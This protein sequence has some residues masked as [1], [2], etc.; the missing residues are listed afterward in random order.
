MHSSLVFSLFPKTAFYPFF[1]P[2]HI[3]RFQSSYILNN[4]D[5]SSLMRFIIFTHSLFLSINF[6]FFFTKL[7]NTS[8]LVTAVS[9]RQHSSS[10]F[11]P[12]V[13]SYALLTF[14]LVKNSFVLNS[15]LDL[16][17]IYVTIPIF[18]DNLK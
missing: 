2:P 15:V 5:L 17:F 10:S 4:S 14:L 8:V 9:Q 7:G 18:D 16:A 13:V 6:F 3:Y 1:C 12:L 11:L